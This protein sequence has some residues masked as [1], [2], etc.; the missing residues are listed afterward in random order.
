MRKKIRLIFAL[1]FFININLLFGQDFQILN[2][3]P[4]TNEV[5]APE[6]NTKKTYFFKVDTKNKKLIVQELRSSKKG[7]IHFHQWLYEIPLN[8]LNKESFEVSNSFNNELKIVIRTENNSIL[9]YMFQYGKVVSIDVS[10]KIILGNWNYSKEFFALLQDKIETTTSHLPIT[11]SDSRKSENNHQKF[12]YIGENVQA[13]NAKMDTD[14]TIGNGYYFGQIE[15]VNFNSKKLKKAL[16]E[17]NIKHNTLLP[18]T[19]YAD[20]NGNIESIF[21][22]NKPYEKYFKIDLSK[23]KPLKPLMLENKNVP[24]KYIFLLN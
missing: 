5:R 22:T 24:A 6:F 18:V 16:K 13:I 21:V 8:T 10:N 15:D 3:L 12:K 7:K 1:T 4:S 23:F 14:L 20:K 11:T 2:D 19:I 17:Q 9:T